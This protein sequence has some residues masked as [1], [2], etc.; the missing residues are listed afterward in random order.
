VSD[1]GSISLAQDG[2]RFIPGMPK[3]IELEHLHRYRIAA[4][5]TAGKRVLDIAS[6]EGYGSFL[7]SKHAAMVTGVDI[8]GEAIAHATKKYVAENLI[9]AVG[10]CSQIP[11]GDQTVDAVVSFETIEHHDQHEQ[12]LLEIKRVLRPNGWLMI[13]SPNKLEYSDKPNYKNPHHVK[14]LYEAEFISLLSKYF[15]TLHIYGQ[16]ATFGSYVAPYKDDRDSS[17]FTSRPHK[18]AE[19][20]ELSFIRNPLYFF[21]IASDTQVRPI[22]PSLLEG[23]SAEAE[24]VTAVRDELKAVQL[25]ADAQIQ[26]RDALVDELRKQISD[27]ERNSTDQILYRDALANE[28]E[29]K[30]DAVRINADEQ[31]RYRDALLAELKN[32]LE[33]TERSNTQQLAHRDAKIDELSLRL[34][35]AELVAHTQ[36]RDRDALLEQSKQSLSRIEASCEDEVNRRDIEILQ[37]RSELAELM[38]QLDLHETALGSRKM[39]LRRILDITFGEH[40]KK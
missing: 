23:R 22:P 29:N 34:E 14:E 32:Q 25:N 24:L 40:K 18:E 37:L 11:L 28:L 17:S 39:L 31:I 7:L 30:L 5:L 27:I 13:S 8:S 33:Q 36:I 3:I 1:S 35:S 6:G 19:N 4:E 2:E 21:A 15:H 16:R 38:K 9:F 26:Y 20:F 10:S 12:M